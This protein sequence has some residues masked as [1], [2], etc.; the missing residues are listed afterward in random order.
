MKKLF[1]VLFLICCSYSF[2]QSVLWM[3]YPAISPDGQTIALEY[4]GD[5]YTVP[6]SG[7]SASPLTIH[8]A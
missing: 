1:T 6:V 2:A 4:K 8:E 7:G 5:I 3:R